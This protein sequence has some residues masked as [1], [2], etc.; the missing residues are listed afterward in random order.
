MD[1]GIALPHVGPQA[2]PQAIVRVAQEAERLGYGAVW[3]LE[4]LLR[5]TFPIP[6]P[7]GGSGLM[8]DVYATAYEPI[9][10][11]TYVA[12]KTERIRLGTSVVDALFHV[13]VVLAKRF[14]TLD[15]FSGGR[16][17]AGLGQGANAPEFETAKVP[18]RRRGAGF[19]EFIGALRAAWGPDPVKF[20][21]RFYTIPESQINPK[22][23]QPGGP[24]IV[25]GGRAPGAVERAAR[26][27]DGLN[28]VIGAWD[29]FEQTVAAF[30]KAA[31]AAGRDPEQLQIIARANVAPGQAASA[32]RA[33]LTG[34]MEQ[35]A[36]DIA[37]LRS[38]RITHVFFDMNFAGTSVDAQLRLLEPL[39]KALG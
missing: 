25:L 13:P 21:G 14:A 34:S 39:K 31:Q 1:I 33:P 6:Q 2:S 17:I 19:E 23:V 7:R 10:T 26:L 8:S 15:Q 12:A 37:R 30:R 28:P 35:V 36:E 18:M 9:E 27:A 11:L 32:P 3:V 29:F 5:P 4:R 22:P 38:L 24:K 20:A 16:V